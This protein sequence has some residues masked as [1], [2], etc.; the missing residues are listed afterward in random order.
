MSTTKSDHPTCGPVANGM[1]RRVF[2][3]RHLALKFLIHSD[4]EWI[5]KIEQNSAQKC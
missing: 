1:A 2:D 5:Y 4:K 3:W